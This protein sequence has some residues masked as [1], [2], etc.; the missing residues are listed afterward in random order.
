MV[1][2]ESADGDLTV[3]ERSAMKVAR[4]ITNLQ[5]SVRSASKSRSMVMEKATNI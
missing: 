3:Q 2:I 4:E 1:G 5:I